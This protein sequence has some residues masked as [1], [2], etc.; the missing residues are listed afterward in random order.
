MAECSRHRFTLIK[1]SG[2]IFL[3]IV[4]RGAFVPLVEFILS[5][6]LKYE[7]GIDRYLFSDR[8][9]FHKVSLELC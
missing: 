6:H 4:Q 5:I 7:H 2:L 1:I 3:S 8:L 9:I